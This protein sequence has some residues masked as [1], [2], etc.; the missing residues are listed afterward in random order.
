MANPIFRNSETFNRPPAQQQ[1]QPQWGQ[2]PGFQGQAPQ[3]Y[4]QPQA[5]GGLMTLDDVIVKTAATLLV[6]FLT[7]AAT[8]MLLP[9]DFLF[10]ALI[11]SALVGF[12]TVLFVARRHTIPVGGVMFYA[13]IEGVFV[14]A[15]SKFFETMFPGIVVSAVLA[16]FVAA[17]ATLAAYKFFNIRVTPKFRKMV[18]IGTAA[19]AGVF[20]VNL[21]LAFMG[22]DTG[23]RDIGSGA[24]MLSIAVS[25]LAVGLAIFNLIVDFDFV[26]RGVASRAPASESWRAAFGITVTMVWLYVEILRILSYFRN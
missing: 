1:G 22:I 19:M 3:G 9:Q 23:I 21:V 10:P 20:L 25:V 13:A 17:G 2:N 16:T 6:V 4:Q 15:I 14:G 7:A 5:S 11:G 24:G 8:F 26:E 18:F 12:V